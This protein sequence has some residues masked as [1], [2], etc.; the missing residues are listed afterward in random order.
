MW[1]ARYRRRLVPYIECELSERERAKV[2]AHLSR[3]QSCAREAELI[4]SVS[5]AL[6]ASETP[7]MEPAPD[8]WAKVSARIER[9]APAA[10]PRPWLRVTQAASA[11]AA[12]VLVAAVGIGLMR[13][14][15]PAEVPSAR[16]SS[17]EQERADRVSHQSAKAPE[18][19]AQVEHGLRNAG[20]ISYRAQ[21]ASETPQPLRKARQIARVPGKRVA[22]APPPPAESV[23][24]AKAD[25]PV[26]TGEPVRLTAGSADLAK[27]ASS[28]LIWDDTYRFTE[29][30]DFTGDE[31]LAAP[32]APAIVAAPEEALA[33]SHGTLAAGG[34]SLRGSE[35]NSP[36]RKDTMHWKYDA[37]AA[38]PATRGVASRAAGDGKNESVVDELNKT[39]GVHIAA[40]FRYP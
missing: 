12:A 8:L 40:L 36:G 16:P 22:T 32:P 18:R 19:V 25:G 23:V 11:C 38:K 33:D 4:K 20:S 5:G 34:S 10:A 27:G 1:C 7:A 31:A 3:C 39:E 13:A 26:A 29:S 15:M 30:S 37:L 28:P 24:V 2:E 14:N 9:D 17:T 6:R 35:P 21:A